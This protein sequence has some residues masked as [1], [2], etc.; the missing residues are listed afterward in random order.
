MEDWGDG[1][2]KKEYE[3]KK[4][5]TPLSLGEMPKAEGGKLKNIPVL[6]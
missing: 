1:S 2:V 4:I 5:L 6:I 3:I